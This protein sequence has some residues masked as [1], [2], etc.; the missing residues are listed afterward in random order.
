MA[1]Y[2]NSHLSYLITTVKNSKSS[3][4]KNTGLPCLQEVRGMVTVCIVRDFLNL[5]YHLTE[6]LDG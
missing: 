2:L 6:V 4:K 1:G 3:F 5:R